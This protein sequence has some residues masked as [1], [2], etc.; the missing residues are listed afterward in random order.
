MN[1]RKSRDD[2]LHSFIHSPNKATADSKAR[3][4]ANF[5]VPRKRKLR[6]S[7]SDNIV[8]WSWEEAKFPQVWLHST[9]HYERKGCFLIFP[10]SNIDPKKIHQG[11]REAE[12]Q[13]KDFMR[14][15]SL[16]QH[17]A[18]HSITSITNSMVYNSS[19]V[20]VLKS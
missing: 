12:L 20:T 6:T 15:R 11:P 13:S 3:K 2:Q 4:S 5:H 7:E 17:Q 16:L 1:L 14:S 10:R 19:L 8:H 18:F 9:H